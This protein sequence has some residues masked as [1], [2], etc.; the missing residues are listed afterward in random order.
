MNSTTTRVDNCFKLFAIFIRW[1]ILALILLLLLPSRSIKPHSGDGVFVNQTFMPRRWFFGGWPLFDFRRFS[2]QFQ[3]FS[4]AKPY[5][6]SYR[7]SNNSDL[8]KPC[9]VLIVVDRMPNGWE[10]TS[11]SIKAMSAR[12]DV[13]LY[14]DDVMVKKFSD[15]I[16]NLIWGVDVNSSGIPAYLHSDFHFFAKQNTHFTIKIDF[17][18]DRSLIGMEGFVCVKCGGVK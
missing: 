5:S 1:F 4:L 14:Q 7:F 6:D 2:I 15:N 10:Y 16:S 12:I 13:E 17:S 18:G 8:A 11:D 3:R 9:Y